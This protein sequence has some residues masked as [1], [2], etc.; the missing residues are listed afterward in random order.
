MPSTVLPSNAAACEQRAEGGEAQKLL[1]SHLLF[2]R[3]RS[4]A[5]IFPTKG[6]SRRNPR[7]TDPSARGRTS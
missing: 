1:S 3:P 4:Q 2:W 7:D 5:P 6:V